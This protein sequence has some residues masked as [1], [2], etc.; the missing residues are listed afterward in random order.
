[1]AYNNQNNV[2][3][4]LIYIRKAY[5]IRPK[6]FNNI[7]NLWVILEKKGLKNELEINLDDYLEKNKNNSKAWLFA[8]D[9][10]NRN[11]NVQK[12][13]T[14]IDSAAYYLPKDSLVIKQKKS[15]H[16]KAIFLPY[17][18]LYNKAFD[19]FKAKKYAE[20]VRDFTE[21]LNKEP[22]YTEA[23]RYRAFCLQCIKE[24]EKSNLDLSLLIP[25]REPWTVQ[26][27][28]YNLR[29]VNYWYMGKSEEACKNFKIATEMGDKEGTDN[30]SKLCQSGKK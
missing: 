16:R 7:S 12:A 5:N 28:P 18:Q 11:G 26:Y 6:K 22:N 10:F 25:I 29:G 19:A 14:V 20:A 23:R 15:I 21:I 27:N 30:Y 13:I 1:M 3:S 4:A 9:F 8:F 2:D 24:Y 17:Q